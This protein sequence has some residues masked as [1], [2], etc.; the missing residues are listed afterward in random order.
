M[1]IFLPDAIIETADIRDICRSSDAAGR[2]AG[3]GA[4][5]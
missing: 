3:P 4:R 2:L 1:A 5:V